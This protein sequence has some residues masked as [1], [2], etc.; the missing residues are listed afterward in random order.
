MP[1]TRNTC[2]DTH[3]PRTTAAARNPTAL[4]RIPTTASG[5]NRRP[6]PAAPMI[7]DTTASTISPSTSSITA[8]PRMMRPSMLVVFWRSASTRAVMPTLVAHSVAP[9]N[10]W[11]STLWAGKNHREQK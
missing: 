1:A 8:A 3:W 10:Q 7:P 2:F 11:V 5:S 6:W 4:A 9:T